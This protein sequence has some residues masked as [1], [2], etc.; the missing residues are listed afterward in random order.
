M[1]IHTMYERMIDMYNKRE[2]HDLRKTAEF[3]TNSLQTLP[4]NEMKPLSSAELSIART[5]FNAHLQTSSVTA[6]LPA[7]MRTTSSL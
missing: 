5:F 3:T 6:A 4:N 7:Y 2:L 1:Y